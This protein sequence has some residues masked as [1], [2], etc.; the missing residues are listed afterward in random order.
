MVILNGTDP[1]VA[2]LGMSYI[3]QIS[4]SYRAGREAKAILKD[5]I[6]YNPELKSKSFMGSWYSVHRLD[7]YNYD[8]DGY[9]GGS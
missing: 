1:N 2:T 8:A 4:S 9:I 7:D 6:L 5:R 3:A